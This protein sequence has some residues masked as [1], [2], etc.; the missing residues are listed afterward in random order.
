MEVPKEEPKKEEPPKV[1]EKKIEEAPKP[2]KDYTEAMVKN[3]QKLSLFFS[4]SEKKKL[5]KLNKKIA[6][7]IFTSFKEESEQELKEIETKF[8]EFKEVK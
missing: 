2:K 3:W 1:E 7:V 8:N 5:V 6:K 4:D